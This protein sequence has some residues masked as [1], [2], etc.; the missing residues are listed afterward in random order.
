MD[1]I[2]SPF[3]Q[4]VQQLVNGWVGRNSLDP[5]G[6]VLTQTIWARPCLQA[7]KDRFPEIQAEVMA[8]VPHATSIEGDL[9]FDHTITNDGKWDKVYIKWYS[10]PTD[11]AKRMFPV[12][13]SIMDRYPDIRLA[14]VS[15]L[16]PGGVIHPHA[17]P[18]R[19]SIR[20]HIGV[21]TPNDPACRMYVGDE[22][23][24]WEDGSVYAFDDTY[25]HMV[26]NNTDQERIILFLDVER[27]MKG[28]VAQSIV[29]F[30]N[31]TIARLTGRE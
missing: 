20:V 30:I 24:H 7:I 26:R 15:R 2:T 22:S 18:W 8:A 13:T 4:R 21:K 19:G 9:F 14:M 16:K 10:E 5:T 11:E 25:I 27:R 12:L 1:W 23:F 31:S 3:G 29:R 6:P 17:G 28:P